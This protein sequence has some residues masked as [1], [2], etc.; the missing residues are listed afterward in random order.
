MWI[1][2]LAAAGLSPYLKKATAHTKTTNFTSNIISLIVFIIGGKVLFLAGI[3]MGSGQMAGAFMGSKLV[4]RNGVGFV[5][6]FFLSVVAVTVTK[7][8]YSTYF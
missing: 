5:R 8:I 1:Q 4:I 7:L 3:I 6:V 2:S